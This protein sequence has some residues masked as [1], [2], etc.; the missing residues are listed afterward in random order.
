MDKTETLERSLRC[1]A[2]GLLGLVPVLGLPAAVLA[3]VQ[4]HK[5][6]VGKGGQWNA[7]QPYLLWGFILG[8]LGL[9]VSLGV[10]GLVL[11]ALLRAF[12]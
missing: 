9:L 4:F 10:V 1:F 2:C 6:T 7:A 5:V 12:G 3:L 8:G 11:A